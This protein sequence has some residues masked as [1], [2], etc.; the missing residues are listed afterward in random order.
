M[1]V[2]G[3]VFLGA[4]VF[5]LV[6]LPLLGGGKSQHAAVGK[7]APDFLLPV[8]NERS[9][10]QDLRLSDLD[11]KVVILDFWASWCGPCRVQGPIVERVAE[12]YADQGVTLV[13]IATSDNRRAAQAYAQAHPSKFPAL[14]DADEN[15]ARAYGAFGLPTLVVLDKR[16]TIVAVRN[17]LTRESQLSALVEGAL[18]GP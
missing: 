14:F 13:G 10:R 1:W 17:G 18:S 9:G 7:Q 11:G 12:H 5:G 6:V 3:L 2:A 4:I 8:I 15:V 16:G